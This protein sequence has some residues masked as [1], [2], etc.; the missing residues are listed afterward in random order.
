[1]M[2][3]RKILKRWDS[4]VEVVSIGV[5]RSLW[6]PRNLKKDD[7]ERW[8]VGVEWCGNGG[9][10][11]MYLRCKNLYSVRPCKHITL[12]KYPPESGRPAL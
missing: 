3:F 6:S 12:L 5:E 10:K 8:R 4:R 1:M 2:S 11:L 9:S 7:I